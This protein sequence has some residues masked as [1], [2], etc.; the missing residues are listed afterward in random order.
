MDFFFLGVEESL[1]KEN[2]FVKL[3]KLLDFS[4]FGKILKGIYV[5]DTSKQGRPSYDSTTMFKVLLLGQWHNLS[6][7]ELAQ[8]LRLRLDFMYYTGFSATD[9]L[10]DYSTINKFRNLL[11]QKQKLKKLLQELNRQL[12][13][14]GISINNAKGAIIDAT[15]V[16]SAARANKCIEVT[17]DRQE[18][19]S[20]DVDISYS[21]D[22]SAR[23]LKKG[24]NNYFGYKVFVS[25]DSDKGF[26]QDIE[27]EP[28]NYYEGHKLAKLINNIKVDRLYAD[29]AYDSCDNKV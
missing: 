4:S 15:L 11:N 19:D 5:Q 29:K 9:S 21:K 23:W 8:A 28:A 7:R 17:K 25:V 14:L 22:K 16:E 10:P 1:G 18:L 20:K 6:D 27:T 12:E 13:K 3:K 2:K 24:N 26:V